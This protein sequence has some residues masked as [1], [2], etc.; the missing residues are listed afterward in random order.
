MAPVIDQEFEPELEAVE[1]EIAK[2]MKVVT[3]EDG[4]CLARTLRVM[5]K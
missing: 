2:R 4:R 5:K 3:T 1:P